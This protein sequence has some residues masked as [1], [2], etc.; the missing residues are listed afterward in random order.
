LVTYMEHFG[1]TLTVIRRFQIVSLPLYC[2]WRWRIDGDSSSKIS[3]MVY[4][5]VRPSI[6]A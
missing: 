1:A 5:I 6:D 3:Y 4:N 2:I